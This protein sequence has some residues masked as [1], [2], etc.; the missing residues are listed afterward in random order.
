MAS[1]RYYL[2]IDVGTTYVKTA[3]IDDGDE[4]KGSFIERAGT[5]IISS[6]VTA[7]EGSIARANVPKTAIIHI[8]ATGFGRR[9]VSFANTI[10]TEISCHAKGAYHYFPKRI[11]IID[12]GGQ[13]TK[14][15]RVDEKGKRLSF[16]MNRKCAAGTGAF[17]EEIAHRLNIPMNEM[18][19][20]A[21]ESRNE[22]SL[23]SF[24]TVF[25]TTEVLLRIK[26]GEKIEDLV[27]SAYESV[28]KRVIEMEELGGTIVMTGG[29]VAHNNILVEILER[30]IGDEILTPPHP[31]LTGA[32]GAALFARGANESG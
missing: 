24:C 11:T 10:K 30:Y 26:D 15:I 29:V 21:T 6:I 2:G 8:T 19:A 27:R 25:A 28:V 1:D 5:D 23:S 14:V 22:V 13:D 32:I 18:N 16:K 17:L 20:L 4:I 31:Q 3:I 9:K 7:F 12:I